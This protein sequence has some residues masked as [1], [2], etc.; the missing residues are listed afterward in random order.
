LIKEILSMIPAPDQIRNRLF[1]LYASGLGK[2]IESIAPVKKVKDAASLTIQQFGIPPKNPRTS[3]IVPLY[4]RYDFVRYQLSH[5]ADDADFQNIDLIYVI[6]DPNIIMPT[7]ELAI[8]YYPVFGVPFRTVSYNSNL[9]FAGANNVGVSIARGDTVLLLN[10]DVLPKDQGWVSCLQQALDSLPDAGAVAPLLLFADESVQ[11]AGMAP[12]RDPRFPGFLLNTH[13]GKGQ[14]W[15]GTS[16]PYECAMLTAA[17][18]M[19][20]RQDYLDLGGLDEGYIIGDFEDSDLCLALIKQ[21]KRL[22]LAPEAKL[23]HLERQSQNLESIAGYRQ[24]L[25][26]YNG[27]RFQKK[28]RDGL[29][30]D[31]TKFIQLE[32]K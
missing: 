27:W 22:W 28:I 23:W 2:A 14:P 20:K 9:G 17:C 29:I 26:L 25:T 15:A 31:P 3:V 5:F 12:K 21:G 8:V 6:D 18:V 4:G 10:S 1:E 11:H 7:Q 32:A 24:L 30:A 19:L 16:A 13:P